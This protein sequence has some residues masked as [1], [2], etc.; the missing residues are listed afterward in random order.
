MVDIEKDIE[1]TVR[2]IKG[3]I[4]HTLPVK[5]GRIA[6]RHF[7]D[8]FRQGGFVN[9]GLHAW[10]PAKRLSSGSKSAAANH[11]T[12]LSSRQRLSTATN[13]IARQAAVQIYN[14]VPYAAI[15]NEGGEIDVRVT[16]KMRR[17]AWAQYYSLAGRDKSGGNRTK[18]GSA[19][20]SGVVVEDENALMWKRLALTRKTSLHI[21]IPQRQYIGDSAELN[22]LTI[23]AIEKG[24]TEILNRQ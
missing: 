13:Y 18:K 19:A 23:A 7:E 24:I 20:K 11:G 14:D 16:P 4:D 6:K 17:F 8:N 12:L 1:K 3:F 2:E 9:N 22:A 15:H 21:R 5:V 10:Q